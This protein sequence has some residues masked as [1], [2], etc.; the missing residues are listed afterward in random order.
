[1]V[2]DVMPVLQRDHAESQYADY[3][4]V[5][6]PPSSGGPECIDY[7]VLEAAQYW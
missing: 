6:Y 3:E 5:P 1:M 4:Q 2:G 7:A